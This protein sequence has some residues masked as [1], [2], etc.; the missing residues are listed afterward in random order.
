MKLSKKV[1]KTIEILEKYKQF[2]DLTTILEKCGY[3]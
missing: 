1:D 3:F 2:D